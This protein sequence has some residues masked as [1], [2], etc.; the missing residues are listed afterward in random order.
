MVEEGKSLTVGLEYEKQNFLNE[1]VFGFNIGN[2]IKDKKNKSM[3]SRAKL[4]QTRSDIVGN[5]YYE[6]NKNINL[7]YNFSYDRDFDF[8]NYD[9][10]KAKFGSNNFIT[11]FDYISENH[12]IG[13]TETIANQTLIKFSN[14][15][16]IQ[17]NTSK[18]LKED[19]TRNYRLSYEYETDCLFATFQYEKK[20]FRDG[21][22]IP[23]ESLLFLIKFIPFTEL[24]G[25][26]NTLFKK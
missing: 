15:H 13:N 20:F 6:P 8:S 5:F 11:S 3:P 7:E 24:R 25:S 19:F 2:T 23:D 17:F 14:E 9:S 18:D 12:E 10:I 16:S 26:A 21:N 4:D 22:L 1:K